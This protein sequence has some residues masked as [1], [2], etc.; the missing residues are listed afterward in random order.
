MPIPLSQPSIPRQLSWNLMIDSTAVV[1]TGSMT[2]GS[3]M[4]QLVNRL[5]ISQDFSDYA[6]WWPKAN[7]WLT[8]TKWTLDQYGVQ[9]DAHLNFTSM[10]KSIRLQLPDLRVLSIT[11][12]FSV[13]V[14]AAVSKLCKDLG[15]R[16]AEELSLLHS[17]KV[18]NTDVSNER[19]TSPR[20]RRHNIGTLNRH[21]SMGDSL[22]NNSSTVSTLCSPTT[23]KLRSTPINETTESTVRHQRP[24]SNLSKSL[25]SLVTNIDGN[26]ARTPATPLKNV[27]SQLVKPTNIIEKS[28]L[29]GLWYDSSKSLMEQNTN[30]NDLILLRFK[31][32]TYYDLNPKFDAVRLNQLYEQAKW[33]VLSE[34]I[35]CTEEEMMTFAALQLQI[36]IQ[37]HQSSSTLT[38]SNNDIGH[39]YDNANDY[40]IDR[41]LERLQDSLLGTNITN[42]SKSANT[43]IQKFSSNGEL[44]DYLRLLKSRRFTFKTLKR[45]WFVMRDTQLTYYANESQ[46]RGTPIEKIS[47]KGCEIL[48]DVHISSKKYAIRLM[49]P[50]LDGMNDTLIR[51]STDEQ[52]A[53]WM[54]AFRLASKGRSINEQSYETER[55]SILALLNMQRPSSSSNHQQNKFD[56]QSENF[57]SPKFVRKYKTKQLTE[58]ILEAHAAVSNLDGTEAKLHYLKAWQA[59]P[60]FGITTFIV[61]FKDSN[62]KEELLGIA[63]NR[64]LRMTLT[65]DTLKTW[66]ISRM[67][68]W[69]V[70]WENRLVTIEF[71]GET[72]HF[73]PLYGIES[74]CI[75]EFIGAYIFLAMRSTTTM[76]DTNDL[77][78]Q[79]NLF[80]RL[81]AAY[82]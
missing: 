76:S 63:S 26:L 51:C 34:D 17:S 22:A 77:I 60:E 3:V 79:E 72:I 44:C 41:A 5:D 82:N 11:A 58:R 19:R 74:K 14:F 29:N 66:W 1:V 23:P 36:Q 47:L 16:H 4:V 10:H 31:Y 48:P 73:L 69:N 61:K 8:N 49:I 27:L 40:D 15:I 25:N 9:S 33:S 71:D 62:K 39:E 7:I 68:S 53:K 75:H 64:L 18:T 46:Q 45:Y 43:L 30:E 52:Y 20:R 57:V 13:S 42:T 32:F 35:D 81:T 65:G 50:S 28:R 59:L 67:R 70:N 56:I 38:S 12:N 6:L 78:Q 55:E 37:S 21:N 80:Q 2:I 24:I 54:A